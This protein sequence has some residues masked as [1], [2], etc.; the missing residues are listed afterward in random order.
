MT[1]SQTT[2]TRQSW[3]PDVDRPGYRGEREERG[4]RARREGDRRS[5]RR[6]DLSRRE[7]GPL[8]R[9]TGTIRH[10]RQ[11]QQRDGPPRLPSRQG[12]VVVAST[13]WHDEPRRC[14]KQVQDEDG[15]NAAPAEA[16]LNVIASAPRNATRTRAP[17][18]RGDTYGHDEEEATHIERV[19]GG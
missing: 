13:C 11:W 6:G 18:S 12:E 19:T 8:L 7:D 3:E 15:V 14:G 9:T 10:T 1:T 16:R 2:A 5:L 17:A 4:T